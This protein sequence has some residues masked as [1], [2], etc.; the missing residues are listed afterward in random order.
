MFIEKNSY[1]SF[2]FEVQRQGREQLKIWYFGL[3]TTYLVDFMYFYVPVYFTSVFYVPARLFYPGFRSLYF[4]TDSLKFYKAIS[5]TFKNCS[6]YFPT[7]MNI[8]DL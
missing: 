7:M 8:L 6:E 1:F 4:L 5:P 3:Q 2:N